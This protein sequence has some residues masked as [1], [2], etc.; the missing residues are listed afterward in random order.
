[1]EDVESG[2]RALQFINCATETDLKLSLFDEHESPSETT[3]ELATSA[4]SDF[5]NVTLGGREVMIILTS[6]A[7]IKVNNFKVGNESILFIGQ[8]STEI[9][10][11]LARRYE[12]R[13]T[14]AERGIYSSRFH[15]SDGL[16]L[17][18]TIQHQYI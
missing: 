6:E 14:P 8:V 13:F 18:Y 3:F 9:M 17:K 10:E 15:P 4:T 2:A 16:S 12:M 7:P 5:Q 11:R 1:V